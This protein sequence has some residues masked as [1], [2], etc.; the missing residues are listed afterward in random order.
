[1]L[2][3]RNQQ[4]SGETQVGILSIRDDFGASTTSRHRTKTLW[5]AQM[6][7]PLRRSTVKVVPC[8][9]FYPAGTP[10]T[11]QLALLVARPVRE[12]RSELRDEPRPILRPV[13]R[14]VLTPEQP[15]LSILSA[16]RVFSVVGTLRQRCLRRPQEVA[17]GVRS[18]LSAPKLHWLGPGLG[19]DFPAP[20]DD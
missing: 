10:Q 13:P 19:D 1:M 14:R 18:G 4:E 7:T 9:H 8:G 3:D 16:L 11:V 6:R 15:L 5:P 20:C 12:S 17:G 2:F